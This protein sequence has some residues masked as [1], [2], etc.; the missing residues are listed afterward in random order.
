[1]THE[2]I[3]ATL[4]S[5][6]DKIEASD[7]NWIKEWAG[8]GMPKNYTTGK[9]YRGCN[10][11]LLWAKRQLE[12]Y[13]TQDWAGYVQWE[14][15]GFQVKAGQRSTVIFLNKKVLKRGGDRSKEEDWYQLL[16]PTLV[17]NAAQ[18][19]APRVARGN[20]KARYWR[21]SI[22]TPPAVVR[23]IRVTAT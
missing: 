4:Q 7:G 19:T 3:D 18:L 17:F 1:M 9:H 16:K 11:L 20:A 21:D 15:A 13:P 6:L 22:V 8:G 12:M 23:A 10:I 14:K 5:L 2:L